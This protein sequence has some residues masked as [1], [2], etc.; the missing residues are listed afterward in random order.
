MHI[1]LKLQCSESINEVYRVCH[2]NEICTYMFYFH[3]KMSFLYLSL[4]IFHFSLFCNGI[5]YLGAADMIILQKPKKI[6][7]SFVYET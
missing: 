1:F 4:L 2:S 3:I 6:Y 7:A 5:M